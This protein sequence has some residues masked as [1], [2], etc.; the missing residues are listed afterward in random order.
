MKTSDEILKIKAVVLYIL[1][2]MTQGVDYIHLFKVMYFAQQEHLKTYGMPIMADSFVARKHG[3]VPT[4]TYR[5]VRCAE[6]KLTA[7]TDEIKDF[8]QS[9]VVTIDHGHQIVKASTQA[10]CDM[11]ELSV[12][13]IEVLDSWIGKCKDVKA[14]DLSNLSHD[15]A[16]E[17]ARQQ[18]E[19]T[20]EDVKIPMYSMAE[21]VGATKEML[22]V[23]KE[24]QEIRKALAWT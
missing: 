22:D 10:T 19:K 17:Q 6:G 1:E 21:A 14:F 4:F 5:A 7:A 13:N 3:P 8:A 24:R 16:W 15:Q 18:A 12:S 9:L 23:I 2:K 11:D 20:G